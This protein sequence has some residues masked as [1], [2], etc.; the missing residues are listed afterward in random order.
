LINIDLDIKEIDIPN[1]VSNILTRPPI[2]AIP[3][4]GM[5][6]DLKEWAD[7]LRYKVIFP[8]I[9]KY[10]EMTSKEILYSFPSDNFIVPNVS[11]VQIQSPRVSSENDAVEPFD[12]L[13]SKGLLREG[14]TL[15]MQY[16]DQKFTAT[17]KKDGLQLD[18]GQVYSPSGAALVYIKRL[19]PS[20][21]TENGW[22]KWKN[23][24]GQTLNMLF[25]DQISELK[26]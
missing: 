2:V 25:T 12:V 16:Y 3:V 7:N 5:P 1:I 17:V 22:I 10:V 9:E 6:V 23:D 4:D 19:N 21:Y 11:Q 24:K 8:L 26:V 20:R 15:Y 13:L 18:D 14:E